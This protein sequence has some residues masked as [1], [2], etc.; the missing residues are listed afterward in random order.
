MN[1]CTTCGNCAGKLLLCSVCQCTYYCDSKCQKEDWK[2]HKKECCA[3]LDVKRE[4]ENMENVKESQLSEEEVDTE[5]IDSWK[6]EYKKNIGKTFLMRFYESF[7]RNRGELYLL[8]RARKEVKEEMSKE[9]AKK[10]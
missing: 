6:K 4:Q 8:E 2:R 7:W 1:T 10:K 9:K 3:N 5:C